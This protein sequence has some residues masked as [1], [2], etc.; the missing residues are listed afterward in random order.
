MISLPP[1]LSSREVDWLHKAYSDVGYRLRYA[2]DHHDIVV[3][4]LEASVPYLLTAIDPL[5]KDFRSA[6]QVAGGERIKFVLAVW[7]G[8]ATKEVQRVLDTYVPGLP[9]N[10]INVMAHARDFPPEIAAALV[11]EILA[12]LHIPV[13]SGVN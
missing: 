11:N 3:F 6:V 10:P 9:V 7:D 12:S 1:R 13:L 5:H 4:A 2:R 8:Q